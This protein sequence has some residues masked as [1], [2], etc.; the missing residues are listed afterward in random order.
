MEGIRC[1]NGMYSCVFCILLILE[2]EYAKFSQKFLPFAMLD[3]AD[4]WTVL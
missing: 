3:K 2:L 1:Q 4:I